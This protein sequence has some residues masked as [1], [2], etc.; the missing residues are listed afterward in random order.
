[1]CSSG[2]W[3]VGVC[4]AALLLAGCAG[5]GARSVTL[6]PG[7]GPAPEDGAVSEP[8]RTEQN[9]PPASTATEEATT[10]PA[11]AA[12]ASAEASPASAETTATALEPP[13]EAPNPPTIRDL[14]RRRTP[15]EEAMLDSARRRLHETVC[16]AN[17]WL[18]GL[19]GGE[20]NVEN[21]RSV[22]GRLELSTIYIEADGTDLKVRLRVNYDL[23]NLEHRF[24]LFL[25]REDSDDA[26]SDT[27]EPLSVRSSAFGLDT[28]EDWLAGLGYSPPGRFA[29]KLD[30]R[31]GVKIQSATE[32]YFQGRFRHTFFFGEHAALRLRETLFWE[33]REDGFG[34]TTALD[35]DRVLRRNL[36]LRWGSVGT[37]SEGT[38]GLA[39]RSAVY[40]YWN[41]ARQRAFSTELFLRG[42]TEA[43]VP[44]REYGVRGVYRRPVLRQWLFGE[45][46]A[47]YTFPR[48]E[49]AD[50][51]EGSAVIG[52]GVDLLFGRDPY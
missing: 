23:P 18:D 29:R 34:A 43:E 36:L 27:R 26:I 12:A 20:P 47:G 51:R 7:P 33:N 14:C 21:A 16:G 31:A 45:I 49:L 3:L 1:M 4:C 30:F 38:E 41:L 6:P 37:Y 25:G 24:N 40:F 46:I 52:F 42:A 35:Y 11:T 48:R 44:L 39:W 22:S 2:R 32:V 15:A 5:G 8:S 13:Q 19:F 10:E 28:E 17:L 50:A 9:A